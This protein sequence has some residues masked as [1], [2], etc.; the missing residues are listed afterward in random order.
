MPGPRAHSKLGT[1]WGWKWTESLPLGRWSPG[2]RSVDPVTAR[3]TV[4]RCLRDWKVSSFSELLWGEHIKRK[5][6]PTSPTASTVH[7]VPGRK[8]IKAMNP[9]A[10]PRWDHRRSQRERSGRRPPGEMQ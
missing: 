7:S 8:V 2:T 3:L 4:T 6:E 9:G 5:K 1:G 10:S